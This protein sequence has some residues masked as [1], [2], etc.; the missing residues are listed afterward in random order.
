[1]K[2]VICLALCVLLLTPVS[3][4][5]ATTNEIVPENEAIQQQLNHFQDL[6][7]TEVRNI[8]L[9]NILVSSDDS[10]EVSL[11]PDISVET[12][13]QLP[14]YNDGLIANLNTDTEITSSYSLHSENDTVLDNLLSISNISVLSPSTSVNNTIIAV[15]DIDI[16][17][18]LFE[19][20]GGLGVIYSMNGNIYLM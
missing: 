18:S 12:V 15:D 5:A 14:K 19:N 9:P 17:T 7:T 16:E 13:A 8:L 20:Q 10:F 11:S 4:N 6:T 2:K 1:M 3:A